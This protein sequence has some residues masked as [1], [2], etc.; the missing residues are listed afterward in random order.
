VLPGQSRRRR[1]RQLAVEHGPDDS[2]LGGHRHR[3]AISARQL[4]EAVVTDPVERDPPAQHVRQRVRRNDR[5]CWQPPWRDRVGVGMGTPT[6]E[7]DWQQVGV[8]TP[9]GDFPCAGGIGVK[10]SMRPARDMNTRCG[11]RLTKA[12]ATSV[13]GS[14]RRLRSAARRHA[15]S[16]GRGSLRRRRCAVLRA[17]DRTAVV[18]VLCT[19]RFRGRAR[20]GDHRPPVHQAFGLGKRSA[21]LC[22][23]WVSVPTGGS[24]A[25][26]RSCGLTTILSETVFGTRIRTH[27]PISTSLLVYGYSGLQ[28]KERPYYAWTYRMRDWLRHAGTTS[29]APVGGRSYIW[30]CSQLVPRAMPGSRRQE[31]TRCE[32]GTAPQR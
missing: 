7:Q 10:T 16:A 6:C 17:R 31:G 13:A 3:V 20:R 2:A 24:K 5:C 14:S 28:R 11:C 29:G 19:Y 32:S 1:G 18:A 15:T 4:P 8:R 9:S 30:C 26:G 12:S 21:T 25:S 27:R 23:Q 22:D